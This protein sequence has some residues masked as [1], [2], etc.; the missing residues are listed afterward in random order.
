M[1]ERFPKYKAAGVQMAAVWGNREATTDK[2]CG[3]AEKARNQ[4]AELIVFPE[5]IIPGSPHWIW[6]APESYDLYVDLYKN[7]V[8]IPGP[9]TEQLCALARKI[10]AFL[11]IGVNERHGKV[12]YNTMLFID[13][14]GQILGARRKLM[15][16]YVEKIIWG[17]GGGESLQ[18]YDTEVGKL[19]GLICRENFSNLARHALAT[20]G[21]QVHAGIWLA[22]SARRGPLFSKCMEASCISHAVSS[23]TYVIGVQ[24]CAAEDEIERFKLKGPGGWS[25]IISPEGEF[26]AGPLPEG[27]GI[28]VGEIDLESSIRSYPRR[29][30][31]GYHGRP[32]VFKVLLNREPY[33]DTLSDFSPRWEKI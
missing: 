23:Q 26:V 18:V 29:D 11:I 5:V 15:G 1:S 2:I 16:T 10:E 24:A 30:E 14:K 25:A 8:E 17:M 7:S 28:A 33:V 31:I 20:Q 9:T 22:G 6:T 27:E 19:G 4:G 21:E 32:D 13:W 3:L 12:L